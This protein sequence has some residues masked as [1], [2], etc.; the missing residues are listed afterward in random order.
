MESKFTWLMKFG[1]HKDQLIID[2]CKKDLKYME[3]LMLQPWLDETLKN[4][5]IECLNEL[6]AVKEKSE[7][8]KKL[9]NNK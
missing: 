3:W 5:I 2:V 1:K 8:L 4:Y 6:D 9:T 7:K